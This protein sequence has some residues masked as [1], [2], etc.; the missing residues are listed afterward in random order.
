MQGAK[1]QIMISF[2]NGKWLCDYITINDGQTQKEAIDAYLLQYQQA[3][4]TM[5]IVS[6]LERDTSF[7]SKPLSQCK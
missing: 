6:K 1:T 5:E 2:D 7:T 4:G 3:Q